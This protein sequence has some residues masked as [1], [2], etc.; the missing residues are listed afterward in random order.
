MRLDRLASRPPLVTLKPLL[1]LSVLEGK[2]A[3]PSVGTGR[4]IDL[5]ML[6]GKHKKPQ[7]VGSHDAAARETEEVADVAATAGV[8]AVAVGG[9]DGVV[10][11]GDEDN[12]VGVGG[13]GVVWGCAEV[14]NVSMMCITWL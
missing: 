11:H 9:A 4:S 3:R 5:R 7:G 1:G 14:E 12:G 10:E 13:V 6:A 8:A 2:V